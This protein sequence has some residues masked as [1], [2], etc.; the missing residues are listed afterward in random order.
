M[1]CNDLTIT[2]FMR[3]L[4]LPRKKKANLHSYTE[5]SVGLCSLASR[6]IPTLSTSFTLKPH[7]CNADIFGSSLAHVV[8][9]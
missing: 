1:S 4:M 5:T 7:I 9:S 3:D 6:P 8:N 2:S